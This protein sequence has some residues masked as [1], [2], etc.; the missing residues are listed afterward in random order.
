MNED[1]ARRTPSETAGALGTVTPLSS[2]IPTSMRANAT[3]GGQRSILQQPSRSTFEITEDFPAECALNEQ[4]SVPDNELAHQKSFHQNLDLLHHLNDP[5]P[6]DSR[7][8]E[9][10]TARVD[11]EVS[12]RDGDH[13]S[14]DE[15]EEEDHAKEV[16][17]QRQLKS[18]LKS[19]QSRLLNSR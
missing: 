8:N 7:T 5:D 13:H 14:R 16:E 18:I 17:V 12:A 11:D 6:E 19:P 9:A 15:A 2:Q 3:F 10:R 4:Q 1:P